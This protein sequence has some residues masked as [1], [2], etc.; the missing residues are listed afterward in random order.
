MPSKDPPELR[1]T[2]TR[3]PQQQWGLCTPSPG[4]GGHGGAMGLPTVGSWPG[5]ERG[6]D[7]TDPPAMASSRSSAPT[8]P[9]TGL[10]DVGAGSCPLNAQHPA[11]GRW[12]RGFG[13]ISSRSS[14]AKRGDQPP[15]CAHLCGREIARVG[16]P[17]PRKR[18]SL[19]WDGRGQFYSQQVHRG[20]VREAGTPL[21][22]RWEQAGAGLFLLLPPAV[23]P[24][25]RSEAI[26]SE[27]PPFK[28]S[29]QSPSMQRPP[30][31]VPS[32]H[33]G[34]APLGFSGHRLS[35]GQERKRGAENR[36]A[37]VSH[38]GGPCQSRVLP[39]GGARCPL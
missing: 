24:H 27:V 36:G 38:V 21:C 34:T 35:R 17:P 30:W 11:R 23:P 37:G 12:G 19:H 22:R 1:N 33:R 2:G 15:S 13:A 6:S 31:L 3:W 14:C 26:I 7:W 39:A 10:G 9:Q 20:Q 5:G 16:T 32:H 8:G 25:T 28:L 18:G 4:T 29:N